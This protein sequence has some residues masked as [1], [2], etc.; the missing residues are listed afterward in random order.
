MKIT[1]NKQSRLRHYVDAPRR[2]LRRARDFYVDSLVSI[3]TKVSTC[4]A[5][6]ASHLPKNFGRCS[7]DYD[8]ENLQ[9]MYTSICNKYSWRERGNPTTG[10][11]GIDRSYSIALGKIGTIDEDEPC[12]FEEN[13]AVKNDL[14]LRS[15]SHAV[16]RNYGF[17]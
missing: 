12:E 3:D 4:P 10:Y 8:D 15:R 11:G 14:F 1:E 16:T 17:H 5:A 6:N 7:S 13:V 9:Q 2:F